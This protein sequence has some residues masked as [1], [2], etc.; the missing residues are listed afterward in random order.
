[1]VF[2]SLINPFEEHHK[3]FNILV[4][5][6][7]Y[8][9]FGLFIAYWI[10][11][12]YSSLVMV[13]LTVMAS[14]PFMYNVIKKEEEKDITIASEKALLE[15]H[16]KAL[17]WFFALFAGMTIAYILW[18]I[19]LPIGTVTT[20]FSVQSATINHINQQITGNATSDAGIMA[21]IFFNNL[22]VLV[23][24]ILFSFL[25]GAGAIFILTWN[26]TV[27]ATAIGSLI[28][29]NLSVA[30]KSTGLVKITSYFGIL[31]IGLLRYSIHGI[32][33][34]LAY[35]VGGLAG[36]IISVAVIRH[37]FRTKRFEKILLDTTDLILIAI[38]ILLLAAV[39]EVYVSPFLA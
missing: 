32:P 4:V 12:E 20:L 29:N 10:F 21:I 27:L 38:A 25:Y 23:F 19:V 33:E 26:S 18:F 1:M 35:L 24:C 7:L 22:K 3:F 37:D 16:A 28:R 5:G 15:E 31:G 34:M 6:F 8:A 36:G 13:F 30:A 17:S 9:T 14:I 2:E 39:L 11:Q